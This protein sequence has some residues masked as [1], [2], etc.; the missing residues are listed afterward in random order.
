MKIDDESF[1]YYYH[2]PDGSK[3]EK[4]G[5]NKDVYIFLRDRMDLEIHRIGLSLQKQIDAMHKFHLAA[6]AIFAFLFVSIGII[7]LTGG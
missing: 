5:N 1:K 3:E 7:C 4:I 6:V 2:H